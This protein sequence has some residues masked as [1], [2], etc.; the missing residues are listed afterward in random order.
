VQ[1]EIGEDLVLINH[2]VAEGPTCGCASMTFG[3]TGYT[4]ERCGLMLKS[5]LCMCFY[6][7]ELP[8]ATEINY[9]NIREE[10]KSF[11]KQLWTKLILSY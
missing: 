11:M 5:K 3:H 4:E 9:Q 6:L 8:V 1:Q 10:Q 2:K 7:I